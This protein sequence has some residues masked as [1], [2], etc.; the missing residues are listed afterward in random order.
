MLTITIDDNSRLEIDGVTQEQNVMALAATLV[1][2][3]YTRNHE[4]TMTC[5]QFLKI[6]NETA[7]DAHIGTKELTK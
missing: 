5:S 2:E 3:I 6:F 4:D 1:H 7:L